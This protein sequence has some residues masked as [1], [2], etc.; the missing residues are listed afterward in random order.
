MENEEILE[1]E[2]I[3]EETTVEETAEN[4]ENSY[5]LIAGAIAG[6]AAVGFAA[7]KLGKPAVVKLKDKIKDKFAANADSESDDVEYET[8]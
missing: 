1:N 7:Y 3:L 4:I 2:D 5:L 8:E 6:I